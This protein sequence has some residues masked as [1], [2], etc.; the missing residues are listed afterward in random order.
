MSARLDSLTD[1]Q[2]RYLD[3]GTKLAGVAIMAIGLAV[4]IETAPGLVL[5]VAGVS[6]G[7]STAFHTEDTQ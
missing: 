3:A 5:A 2:F 1:R 6:L 7:V 4:G